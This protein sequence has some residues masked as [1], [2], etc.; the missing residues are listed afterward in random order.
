MI[1]IDK[2]TRGRWGNKV[3]Q[4]NN[5]M[6]LANILNID[7]SCSHWEGEIYFKKTSRIIKPIRTSEILYWDSILNKSNDKLLD[8]FKEKNWKLDDPSYALHNTFYRLTNKDPRDFMELQDTFQFHL[9]NVHIHIGI[10]IRGGDIRGGDGQDGR[11]IHPPSYYIQ[12]IQYLE[13]IKNNKSNNKPY[14]YYICTD[15]ANFASFTE[16]VN[17]LKNNNLK[18]RIGKATLNP[19]LSYIYDFSLLS[20]C[21]ILINSSSTFCIAAGFLGKKNK[22][23][24]HYKSWMDKIVNGDFSDEEYKKYVNR[25]TYKYTD[26]HWLETRKPR[27]FWIDLYNGGNEYYKLWKII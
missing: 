9:D 22:K 24:I 11:E 2:I 15:E 23:I 25:W 1:R 10:H 18:Y 14:M 26:K 5:L 17:Y 13:S 20:D 21:D 12:A 6:Q 3:L 7:A 16:T 8:L 4:Y 19:R 27:Q